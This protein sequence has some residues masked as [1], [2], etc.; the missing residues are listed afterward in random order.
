MAHPNGPSDHNAAPDRPARLFRSLFLSD[1]HLGARGCKAD[2]IL[3]FLRNN[4]ADTIYLVGDILDTWHPLVPHWG[5]AHDEILRLLFRRARSGRRVIYLP[6]NHDDALRAHCGREAGK[7]EVVEQAVHETANGRRLLVLHGDCADMRLFRS[8]LSTRVG[9]RVDG[10]L[11]AL[12]DRLKR[13]GRTLHPEDR[14]VI[15]MVLAG[16]K[17]LMNFGDGFELRLTGMAAERGLD[18]V[19]CGH[20]HQAAL[21]DDHGGILYAN[22]GDWVD[23]FTAIAEDAAGRLSL[24]GWGGPVADPM[25]EP[26]TS[27]PFPEAEAAGLAG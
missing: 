1:F 12:D 23:S 7:F 11:R 2:R 3:D 18:G 6:G 26:A 27:F 5:A 25:A 24:I 4:D 19:I 20:S 15:E 21:H 9:S 13:W 14:S 8:H 17:A 22:C 10:G 16:I